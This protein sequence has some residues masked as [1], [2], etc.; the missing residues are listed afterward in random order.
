MAVGRIQGGVSDA[1][2]SAQ[3]LRDGWSRIPSAISHGRLLPAILPAFAAPMLPRS[4]RSLTERL[5]D[6]VL[7]GRASLREPHG[8]RTV[9]AAL[10][11]APSPGLER[12]RRDG[13]HPGH[14]G[15]G[16]ERIRRGRPRHVGRVRRTRGIQA[17][18]VRWRWYRRRVRGI[19]ALPHG[20]EQ[21]ESDVV[22]GGRR[23]QRLA[24]LRRGR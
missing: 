24:V 3:H 13:V 7:S 12:P 19:V 8:H 2:A 10:V 17:A 15:H 5:L 23:L 11:V 18:G 22:S 4:E 1:L 16:I 14:Q 21:R 6:A 20:W 9:P